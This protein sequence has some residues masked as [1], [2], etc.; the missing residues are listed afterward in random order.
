M[1]ILCFLPDFDAGGAQRTVINLANAFVEMGEDAQ[2]CATRTDGKAQE[3]VAPGVETIDLGARRTR[4]SLVALTRLL[5]SRQPDILF[6]S[7]VDANIVAWAGARLAAVPNLS[8][9]LRETNS[10]LARGDLGRLRRGLIGCAYRNADRVVAL[11]SGVAD[12]IAS[13]YR[14]DRARLM[15]IPNPV[16]VSDIAARVAAGRRAPPPIPGDGPLVVSVGRLTRQKGFDRLIQAFARLSIP[17]ARLAIVGEG[18]DHAM[19]T[20]L[21][22]RLGVAERVTLPGFAPNPEQWLARA[23][24]FVSSSRWEGFGHVIVEAMAAGVPVVAYDCPHGPRDILRDGKNGLLVPEG[25]VTQLVAA[26]TRVLNQPE[27]AASLRR[28]AVS[29]AA[30]YAPP[31]I[32]QLY[33]SLFEEARSAPRRSTLQNLS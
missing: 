24:V 7:M 28:A 31:V 3:W 21:A 33:Y 6:A 26:L 2:L 32:A 18:E 16:A 5:R 22:A 17:G 13:L 8:V 12:E 14:L 30:R 11:S 29:D 23:D 27:F 4:Y 25:D 9:V 20:D 1:R 10:H 15:T 19:L